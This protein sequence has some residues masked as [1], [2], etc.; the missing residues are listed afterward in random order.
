MEKKGDD[1]KTASLWNM[2]NTTNTNAPIPKKAQS[3]L[4]NA[5]IKEHTEYT[6]DQIKKWKT[7]LKI[8][9]QG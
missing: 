2:K 1:E 8:D 5:Y 6:Q 4:N 7:Q 9:N 3:E